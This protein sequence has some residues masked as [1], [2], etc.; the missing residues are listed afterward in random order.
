MSVNSPTCCIFFVDAETDSTYLACLTAASFNF[1]FKSNTPTPSAATATPAATYGFF[2][3]IG[4]NMSSI[5][6]AI[7][8]FPTP[9]FP[10]IYPAIDPMPASAPIL[11]EPPP[12]FPER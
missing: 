1:L 12:N 5:E 2:V 3:N 4:F 6:T 9:A 8:A 10:L 11:P 7:K